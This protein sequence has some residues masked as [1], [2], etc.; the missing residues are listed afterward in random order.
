MS[1]GRPVW[2]ATRVAIQELLSK[3][4]DKLKDNQSLSQKVFVPIENV[5]MHLPAAIG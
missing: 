3:E 5:K 1:L 2:K 4:N